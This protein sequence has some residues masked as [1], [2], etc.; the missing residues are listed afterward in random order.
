VRLL[1]LSGRIEAATALAEES[2]TYPQRI[3]AFEQIFSALL[4]RGAWDAA[5]QFVQD[6]E[7]DFQTARQAGKLELLAAWTRDALARAG[8]LDQ[9]A[10]LQ[11]RLARDFGPRLLTALT[12]LEQRYLFALEAALNGRL[13]EAERAWYDL[14][15][16]GLSGP[17]AWK[18]SRCLCLAAIRAKDVA[19]ARAHWAA[20]QTLPAG[21]Q[22]DYALEIELGFLEFDL[23]DGE[24]AR[25]L[26]RARE[27]LV[28][29][30]SPAGLLIAGRNACRAGRLDLAEE[31]RQALSLAARH[32]ERQRLE[33]EI[34]KSLFSAG[35]IQEALARISA[36]GKWQRGPALALAQLLCEHE[37]S[38]MASQLAGSD[39]S[40][41][42]AIE[43][44]LG[45][46]RGARGESTA[47]TQAL[48]RA[49]QVM[50]R[51]S[52]YPRIE[53]LNAYDQ[54]GAGFEGALE[55]ERLLKVA[56]GQL[57][58]QSAEVDRL[59]YLDLARQEGIGLRRLLGALGDG[60]QRFDLCLRAAGLCLADEPVQP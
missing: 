60:T 27:I 11:E 49:D 29:F 21:N 30:D 3:E 8:R 39:S 37:H 42:Q 41:A 35:N 56:A 23:A 25:A 43:L 36:E 15:R 5:G 46:L 55:T 31:C 50:D 51:S 19:G 59:L 12:A 6:R 22:A 20:M 44:Q 34:Q 16:E 10:A 58:W 14:R 54:I 4:E 40:L 17:Q 57:A 47:R 13:P 33:V 45:M 38:E 32:P 7:A 26:D 53:L 24:D 52:L 9:C 18:L 28:R 2:S 48:S 1:A